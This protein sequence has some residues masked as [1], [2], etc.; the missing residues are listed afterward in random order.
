MKSGNIYSCVSCFQRF[1]FSSVCVCVC[2]PDEPE[3]S[4]DGFDGN[5]YLNRENVQLSCQV[6]ANPGVSLYQWRL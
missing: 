4:V 5:W 6:D 1:Y 3:V 2:V